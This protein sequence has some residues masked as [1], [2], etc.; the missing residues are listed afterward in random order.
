MNCRVV[1]V[2]LEGGGRLLR[3]EVKFPKQ[4]WRVASR[5]AMFPGEQLDVVVERLFAK[6]DETV[7]KLSR[8]YGAG[9]DKVNDHA[10]D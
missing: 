6:D 8:R 7:R 2:P 4:G 9:A 10:T 1:V 3:L 5:E